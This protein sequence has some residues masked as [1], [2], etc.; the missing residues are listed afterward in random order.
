MPSVAPSS[1]QA[2]SLLQNLSL[3]SQPKTIVGDA[4]PV[5][6]NGPVFANG[7]AKGTGKPF[8]PN[9]S[10]VPNGYPSTYYYGGYDGQGDWSGYSNYVNLDGGMTQGVYGD[11]CS[12]MYHQGYGYTP[13]GAYA[14]PNSSSPVVQHDGQMYGLQQYQ[15]PCSYYN[16]PTSADGSFAPNKTSVPQRE[17]STAVNADRITS[18]VMNKGNSVSMVNGDCTNQNG[19]KAFMKSSQ[20]TSLNTKDSYQGSSLPA[21]APLSGY[22]GPRLSTHGAQSAIPTDVSL[23]SDRQSKHGGKVGLSSQVANIKDFSSQRNQRHSQSLP[24][25]MNLNGSRHPS[26]MELLP[27]FMNG[28]YPSNNLFSQYGSSFRANSRYGSSAYGSRTG[29]FDN[30]YR[31]TGNGYV[32]NDSRRNGDGFSELNKGPRAAKSSDNKS[33]KSPEPVTLLLK[34]QNLPVKSDDEVV[35]LVLNKEQYNGE[36]LSENYSDAK[37]FIIKSY[38]EDDVHK[39]IKYSV[40]AS[41]PNGNK[42]L[43]AAYQEAGGC[44]IFLLFSVNTS[45]QFVGLAEMTGP[46]DFDKTVEYWQQDRWTGCFNVKWHIIKDIP[47][48]VLRHI[49]LENN[50]NKPVTN[51]RDTQEVKFEKGVQIVKIFK[52]HA[53][54]TSILDDFGFYESRE[55]TTQ[56]RKFKE[57]QLPKQVNKASDITFGSVTLP[58]SLDTTLMK[59]SATADAAQGNVNSEVLLERN[60]STPAFED[61]SKSS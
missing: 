59:E 2:A 60:G 13:Y 20:H 34:G 23:V 5:K 40:W 35:P 56:E 42:K 52:E 19:L 24:Q 41:T 15:Y 39:S 3:D 50:E 46:V 48:G 28:M 43:D 54:K 47:N 7:A 27:G 10:Y 9:P 57:Q 14:S 1:E 30:K 32:A 55:K 53:S 37:F 51:S 25:F 18:N 36:D 6:K 38:S 61:S 8:N 11:N 33:V 17:M 49:T 22:Q 12:Y 26:G 45:G 58:K 16:S 4:E 44:P 21:C 29:S 31:A